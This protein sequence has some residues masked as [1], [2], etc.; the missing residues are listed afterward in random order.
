MKSIS[1][2]LHELGIKKRNIELEFNKLE[3]QCDEKRK[4]VSELNLS[5][6]DAENRVQKAKEDVK[7]VRKEKSELTDKKSV[8]KVELIKQIQEKKQDFLLQTI[9]LNNTSKE[10]VKQEIRLKELMCA[11]KNA[12]NDFNDAEELLIQQK[13]LEKDIESKETKLKTLQNIIL[14]LE[15]KQST[16]EQEIHEKQKEVFVKEIVLNKTIQDIRVIGRRVQKEYEKNGGT[17]ELPIDLTIK[18]RPKK[19]SELMI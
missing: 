6:T 4:R 13:R 8:E 7:L 9:T 3:I 16:L 18:V 5:A 14:S 10:I 19:R 1:T 11:I 17:F 15:K 2:K 12:E